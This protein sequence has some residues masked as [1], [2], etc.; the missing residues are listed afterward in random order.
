[1]ITT[2]SLPALRQAARHSSKATIPELHNGDRL[3]A[4]AFLDAYERMPEIKKAELIR[5]TVFMASPVSAYFHAEPDNL[6]QGLLF[7]FAQMNEG[8]VAATNVTVRLGPDDVIQP[9]AILRKLPEHG[10]NTRLDTKG[11]VLGPPEFVAEIAASSASIDLND[12]RESCRRAG[13]LEYFVW[14]TQTPALHFWKLVDGELYEPVEPVEGLLHSQVF[15]H[16]RFSVEALLARNGKAALNA[17]H[18]N[19]F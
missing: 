4:S 15:P 1:M 10:G 8:V 16:L 19:P 7:Y 9:D 13:V 3:C 18:G 14:E 12:K 2:A 17:M 11:Y 6:L 5:N